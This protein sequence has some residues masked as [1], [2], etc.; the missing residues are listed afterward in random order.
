MSAVDP[1]SVPRYNW[2]NLRGFF[3]KDFNTVAYA[4][5]IGIPIERRRERGRPDIDEALSAGP[6]ERLYFPNAVE[7]EERARNMI[8]VKSDE[9]LVGDNIIYIERDGPTI[10]AKVLYT[11]VSDDYGRPYK[12]FRL[13][14]KFTN[15]KFDL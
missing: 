11:W 8:R 7:A 1:N 6:D 5:R 9:L 14:N 4:R 10:H 13:L 2:R 3:P 12:I 15:E